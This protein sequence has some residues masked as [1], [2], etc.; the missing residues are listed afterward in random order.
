M[1]AEELLPTE[2]RIGNFV[3]F[4]NIV[5][6]VVEITTIGFYVMQENGEN[7][8]NTWADL[9]PIPL[10]EEWL[11]K[12]GFEKEK[13]DRF[14]S[15]YLNETDENQFSRQ[16][17]DYWFGDDDFCL[18]RAGVCFKRVKLQYIHQLQNLYFALTG[19]ELTIKTK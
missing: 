15:Y 5:C 11:L 4:E 10:T 2:V 13:R 18:C 19:E 7:Y 17:I 14:Y 6:K 1:K 8:K 3:G 16:R 9:Q 12:F